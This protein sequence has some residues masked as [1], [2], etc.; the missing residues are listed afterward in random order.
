MHNIGT[1]E[2]S[3]YSPLTKFNE[4]MSKARVRIFTKGLN[5]NA[6]FID[7]NVATKLLNTLTYT[8]IKGIY[9]DEHEDFRG[10]RKNEDETE[11]I[12]GFVPPDANFAWEPFKDKDGVIRD[13][14]CADV[15]LWT[16]IYEEAKSIVGKSQSME[17]HRPSINGFWEEQNG[18][19]HF[20]F[21]D[22]SFLGL[23]VLGDDIEPA[24]DSAGF[25]EVY[26]AFTKALDEL[27]IMEGGNEVM[28]RPKYKRQA[29]EAL[30]NFWAILNPNFSAE[31]N[32][33][34]QTEILSVSGETALT[35]NFETEEYELVTFS[36]DEETG[37]YSVA[38][39]EVKVLVYQE[40]VE[41]GEPEEEPVS[42]EEVIEEEE[43]EEGA[44]EVIEEEE[45]SEEENLENGTQTEEPEEQNSTLDLE[46]KALTAQVDSLS[47]D[48]ANMEKELEELRE[49]KASVEK[50][51]K[52]AV[53]QQ[54]SE[55][56]SSEIIDSY[57]AKIDSYAEIVDL[58][59]DL[60]YEYARNAQDL[61]SRK[62]DDSIAFPKDKN[63]ND[64][65][66]ILSLYPKK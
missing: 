38:E 18:R 59:K 30:E 5:V 23:Q 65:E 43:V 37:E 9:S 11:K 39:K 64:I 63:L 4:T 28:L 8:P 51:R 14:A 6:S 27:N 22:A 49:Y 35:F 25:Y 19:S 16:S 13:Y 1:F 54:Y 57:T 15:I 12:Y 10:H 2:V 31:G 62:E 33:E 46:N 29:N 32:W 24:F 7:E 44:E 40:E 61:F 55:I 34:I 45:K 17:L 58:E 56:L 36:K 42:E 21:T 66:S 41:E 50:A 53:L 26:T 48:K 20:R 47:A 60:A 3:V 52:E